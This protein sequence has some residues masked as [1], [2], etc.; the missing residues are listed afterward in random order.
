[1]LWKKIKGTNY[2]VSIVGQIRNSVTGRIVRGS[3]NQKGYLLVE[4]GSKAKGGKRIYRTIH[5]LVAEAFIGKRPSPQ[6]Q[7]NHISGKKRDNSAW[8]LEYVT[9]KEN[10]HHCHRNSLYKSRL[11]APK[12]MEIFKEMKLGESAERVSRK[13]GITVRSAKAISSGKR[14]SSVTGSRHTVT[15]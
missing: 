15:I 2:E 6:H 4:I 11:S 9:C 8:N 7:I 10:V 3:K 13:F 14:W 1:M 12:V 5:T